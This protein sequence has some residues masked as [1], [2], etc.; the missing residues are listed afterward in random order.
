VVGSGSGSRFGP[1]YGSKRSHKI[2]EID[3]FI[4]F[5]LVNGRIRISFQIRIIEIMM[6]PDPGGPK[7][8]GPTGSEST[9]LLPRGYVILRFLSKK[10]IFLEFHAEILAS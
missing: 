4:N 2:V 1:D 5:L 8:Y 10:G 6:D 9:T 3:L 7:T